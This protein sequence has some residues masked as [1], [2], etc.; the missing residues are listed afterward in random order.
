[1]H[2]LGVRCSFSRFLMLKNPVREESR[3]THDH[4]LIRVMPSHAGRST[5]LKGQSGTKI[6]ELKNS[7][8]QLFS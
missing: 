7:N 3:N 1:M 4:F 8:V 6:E 5:P 2:P